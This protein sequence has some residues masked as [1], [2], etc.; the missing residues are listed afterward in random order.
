M[1]KSQKRFSNRTS[2]TFAEDSLQYTVKDGT[3]RRTFSVEY[4]GISTDTGEI[5]ERNDWYRNVGFFWVLIGVFL[6]YS[7]FNETG[8]I[9]ISIWLTLGVI[10]FALY[11]F[12]KTTF[13]TLDSEKGRI[14]IIQDSK[15]DEIKD[16]IDS[17]RKNQWFR[18]YGTVDYDNEPQNEIGKFQWLLDRDV[19]TEDQFVEFRSLILDHHGSQQAEDPSEKR[20][21]N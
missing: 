9:R 17:R 18:W 3:G 7:R 11:G 4:A 5:E 19:I 10:C 14:F 2:F 12:L 13:T 20:T 16:E 21:L 15:H 6:S 1:D 8:E